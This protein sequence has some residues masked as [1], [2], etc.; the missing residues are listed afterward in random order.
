MKLF[1]IDPEE[2]LLPENGAVHYFGKIFSP[3]AAEKYLHYLLEEIP[4]EHDE[5]II[6]G[7]R[8]FTKRK[9]AWYGDSGFSYTYSSSTK[10]AL[11]WSEKL[12]LLKK[13]AEE[14]TGAI[15]NSCL[16][17]LYHNGEEGVGWHSDDEKSLSE[18]AAIAALSFGAERKFS[19]KH[20]IN[21]KKISVLL[22]NGS[23]LVMKNEIQKFWKHAILKSTLIKEP[24]VSLTFR[25]MV[26]Q[27]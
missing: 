2:N 27:S 3:P 6:F 4:W 13:I 11:P 1:E 26:L 16:L 9:V 25:N 12:L 5:A 21:D 22:E 14:K 10:F 24:R 18:N 7:K 17:N 19:F 23:L 8:I 20:K 15:Y